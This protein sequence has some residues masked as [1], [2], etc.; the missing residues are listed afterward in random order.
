MKRGAT[1]RDPYRGTVQLL[2]NRYPS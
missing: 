2:T 1:L